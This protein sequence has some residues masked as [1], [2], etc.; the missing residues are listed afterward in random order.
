MRHR[1]TVESGRAQVGE[2][3][4][5]TDCKSVRPC[6]VRWFESTPVHQHFVRPVVLTGGSG[7]VMRE[8]RNEVMAGIIDLRRAGRT[9]MVDAGREDSSGRFNDFGFLRDSYPGSGPQGSLAG[10]RRT[11]VARPRP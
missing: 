9:G 2:R 1:S 5:P 8:T 10:A 4:K 7:P 6:G 11:A 3:L